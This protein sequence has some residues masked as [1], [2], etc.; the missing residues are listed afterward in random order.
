MMGTNAE[1]AADAVAVD[2]VAATLAVAAAAGEE[3]P[4][5]DL[6]L[7]LS[8]AE[9]P[10]PARVLSRARPIAAPARLVP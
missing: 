2:D 7:P 5:A 8:G 10:Q 1:A 6:E 9:L 4:L 3:L